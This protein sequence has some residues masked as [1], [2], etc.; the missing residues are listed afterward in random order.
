MNQENKPERIQKVMA[1]LGIASRRQAEDLIAKGLVKV[2]GEL[3]TEPGR[4]ISDTDLIEIEGKRI[5]PSQKEKHVYILLHKPEGV[6]SSATD[7]RNRRTVVDLVQ[8]KVR[9]RV[10]PVGRLDYDTSGLILLT[11]DGDLT[12]R[13]T[14]P[15]YGVTKTYRAWLKT[16]ISDQAL[17]I[18][19]GG[20]ALEDG[21]TS[22][23]K[24]ER[25]DSICEKG[26]CFTIVE[27]SIHEGK[28]RQ[29]RRMFDKVGYPVIRLQRIAFG[30]IK[31]NERMQPGEFRPLSPAEIASLK[32]DVGLD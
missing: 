30:T 19:E 23:S 14:H 31:L 22:P 3:V 18:L 24:I 1:R 2:N 29:V 20:V 16:K 13:L 32:K 17:K 11:N 4:K 26:I 7:P 6:L 8:E 27:L 25:V 9:E 28:N 12:Y 10:Y 15:S 5:T 21:I